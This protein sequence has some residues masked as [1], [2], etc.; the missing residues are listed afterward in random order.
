M[1]RKL[2]I[3][4]IITILLLAFKT[5]TS[6]NDEQQII[7]SGQV[8]DFNPQKDKIELHIYRVFND[9]EIVDAHL[10]SA[11]NFRFKFESP[12]PLETELFYESS[13]TV[14]THPG[15]SIFVRFNGQQKVPDLLNTVSF[16]G[17]SAKLNNDIVAFK[18]MLYSNYVPLNKI[19]QSQAI[20]QFD[21][22]NYELYI[23]TLQLGF[24][25]FLN[26]FTKQ[27]TPCT[28]ALNW[29]EFYL[30]Q[31]TS[32]ALVSY[33]SGHQFPDV[34]QPIHSSIPVSFYDRLSDSTPIDFSTFLSSKSLPRYIDKYWHFYTIFNALADESYKQNNTQ[35]GYISQ[36]VVFSDSLV[37]AGI[38]KYTPD[39][40]LLQL[41][42]IEKE[43]RNF[44]RLHIESYDK[45]K[46]MINQ[47]IVEPFLKD[48][49][50][51]NYTQ[52]LEKLNNPQ[53]ASNAI[54]KKVNNSPVKALMDSILIKNK[55]KV[56]YI[57]CWAD[58]CG[59]CLAELPNS[60]ILEEELKDE[61]IE[62]VYLCLNSKEDV[63]R[64]LLAKH[65]LK[66]QHY[67]LT[68][69]QSKKFIKVFGITG[70]PYYF[71]IDKNKTIVENGSYLTPKVAK[72]KI[73][74]LLKD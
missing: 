7:I 45:N 57:D 16:S 20:M 73:K 63:W 17:H 14:L 55:G 1:I 26:A 50:K 48:I 54:L 53:I 32:D 44:E 21:V 3:L 59:P 30:N 4:Q 66:G 38:I 8:L 11:G 15:D 2:I 39:E 29:G 37:N 28:E 60:K 52:T 69:N 74:K 10:D 67:F 51:N 68:K 27:V 72:E 22:P 40:L 9:K 35:P 65:Q 49:L 6:R 36:T 31:I 62:F 25:N 58:Y 46:E 24:D 13:L 12:I 18:K 70:V 34:S 19:S 61:D 41:I 43:L 33:Y 23:D 42:L 64:A 71:L 47:Q 5:A 56:I